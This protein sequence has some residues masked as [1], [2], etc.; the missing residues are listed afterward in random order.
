MHRDAMAGGAINAFD[1][2]ETFK[3]N[4]NSLFDDFWSR[5]SGIK[6]TYFDLWQKCGS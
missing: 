2:G 3:R 4:R 6:L 1:N 5:A